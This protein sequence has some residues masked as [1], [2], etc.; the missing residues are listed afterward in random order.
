[1]KAKTVFVLTV[2]MVLVLLS[3]CLDDESGSEE[4][5]DSDGD[6]WSDSIDAFPD[7]PNEWSDMDGD[8]VGDFSDEFPK[9]PNESQDSDGDG[10]GDNSDEFPDDPTKSKITYHFVTLDT[11]SG[12]LHDQENPEYAVHEEEILLQE[13][14]ITEIY[15]TIHVEDSD[16]EHTETDEGS[17]PDE[18]RVTVEDSNGT[19]SDSQD[20]VTPETMT[21]SWEADSIEYEDLLDNNWTV[22]IQGIEF[23][24]GKTVYG[25]GG[26]I[27]YIDQGVAWTIDVDY[28]YF[29]I[30]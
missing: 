4:D 16:E 20:L 9:D 26:T 21:V 7:D 22:T 25:P 5:V 1:V 23:G 10:I 6:G 27:V 15:F 17:D 13:T 19:L 11:I 18:V 28:E 3:G 12:W 30:E 29:V 24:G 14:T 8:G 2:V